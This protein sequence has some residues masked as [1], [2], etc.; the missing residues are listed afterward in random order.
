MLIHVVDK[1][2]VLWQIAELYDVDINDII[3][4]NEL[5]NPNLLLEGQALLIPIRSI[6]YTVKYGDTL[7][8]IAQRFKV[9]LI[10]LMTLNKVVNPNFIYP[11]VELIIPQKPRPAI[12]VNAYTFVFGENDIPILRTGIDYLTYLTPFTY[13]VGKDGRLMTIN[14]E[15][16]I[17]FALSNNVIPVMCISNFTFY[18]SGEDT[19]HT[20]LNDRA[21]IN[22]LIDNIIYTMKEKGYRGLNVYFEDILPEDKEAY[23]NFMHMTAS[24]LHAEGLFL[25]ASLTPQLDDN[26]D[27]I[28]IHDYESL[29]RILDYV[30]LML[31]PW[32]KMDGSPKAVSSIVE[33]RKILDYTVPAIPKEKILLGYQIIAK[34]WAIPFVDGQQAETI[35]M[36]TAMNRAYRNRA[37]IQ[38]DEISQSPFFNYRDGQGIIHEV[39][40]EDVRS[41]QA[42]YDVIKEFGLR[43]ISYWTLGYPFSQSGHLLKGNFII[44]KD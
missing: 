37:N 5:T 6:L 21:I 4:T 13:I 38:Y 18:N 28:H 40:F 1:G 16:A 33:I 19:A 14:D 15:P 26:G 2:E 8:N 36:Q 34:D 23:N 24:M 10:D 42:K 31:N 43:G 30:I 39:W 35:N 12:E 11:G 41:A 3:Q 27:L 9:S 32:D 17:Q 44:I 22:L 25:S 29:G 7:W 20:V